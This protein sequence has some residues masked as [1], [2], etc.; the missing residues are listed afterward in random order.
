MYVFNESNWGSLFILNEWIGEVVI[1]DLRIERLGFGFE[2]V[3]IFIS[4]GGELRYE[5]SM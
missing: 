4:L 3:D 1:K 2:V 5:I